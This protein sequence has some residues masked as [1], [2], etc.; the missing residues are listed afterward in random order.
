MKPCNV[1]REVK[2]LSAFHKHA[3]HTDGRRNECIDCVSEKNHERYLT[4]K[5]EIKRRNGVWYHANKHKMRSTRRRA[6]LRR[7]YGLQP[8][9]YTRM[10]EEQGG[11]CAVCRRDYGPVLDVDHDHDT[12]EVR[13]LLCGPCNRALGLLQDSPEVVR[14]LA[15]YI[16]RAKKVK[17]A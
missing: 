7:V 1:C 11:V 8:E 5:E 12:G 14:S 9:D 16:G 2:P 6:A 15:G 3:Q 13:G 10:Y 17:A 4:H